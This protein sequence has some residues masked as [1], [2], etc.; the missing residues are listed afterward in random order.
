MSDTEW[1]VDGG[2]R[3][4]SEIQGG[5]LANTW[6]FSALG[7]DNKLTA[8]GDYYDEVGGAFTNATSGWQRSNSKVIHYQNLGLFAQNRMSHDAWLLSY[9]IRVDDYSSR[10]IGKTLKGS[11]TSLNASVSYAWTNEIKTYGGYGESARGYGN[12]PIHFARAVKDD[13]DITAKAETARHYELGLRY[14]QRNS[15]FM[16]GA[17]HADLTLFQTEIENMILY[18]HEAGEGGMGSRQVDQIYNYGQTYE[19]QGYTLK[20]GWKGGRLDS[21][22][23]YTHTDID[24]LPP[25]MHFAARTGAPTGDTLVWDNQF[26]LNQGWALGYTLTSVEALNNPP[27]NRM[28]RPGYILHDV[29]AKWDATKNLSLAFAVNNLLDRKYINHTTLEQDGFATEE[30]GRDIRLS[31]RYD[32]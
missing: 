11:E 27:N 8:G 15:Q 24:N 4:T 22:V 16:G 20:A 32:F 1:K 23:S 18:R 2:S 19:V 13:A 14:D 7:F 9:G 26:Y 12:I 10:Y 3:F 17:W 29:Q 30:P 25:Q 28:K 5:K 21:R 31:V 6:A